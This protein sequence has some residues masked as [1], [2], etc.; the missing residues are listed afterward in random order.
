MV[1]LDRGL[2][3][4]EAS[5]R[6]GGGVRQHG[7]LLPEVP[8]AIAAVRMWERLDAELG[9]PTSY[10]QC[11][12]MYVAENDADMAKLA[13][14]RDG[15]MALGLDSEI[16]GPNALRELAPAIAGN[17]PGAKF[18]PTDGAA[19]PSTA[20]MA[21]AAAAEEAGAI[22]MPHHAVTAIGRSGNRVDH[23][24]AGDLRVEAPVVVN[25][26]GPWAPRIAEMVDV[27]LPIYPSRANMMISAPTGPIARPFVQTA[28]MDMAVCQL[29]DGSVRMGSGATP[30]DV[31]RF[32]YRKAFDQPLGDARPPPKVGLL[33]PALK[34]VPLRWRW[35]GIRECTPD[36]MPIIGPVSGVAGGPEGF[37]VSAGYSGH[38]FCLGPIAGRLAAE[39]LVEGRPSLDLSAFAYHR[40]LRPEGPLSVIKVLLEQTG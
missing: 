14:M 25:A 11:G 6:N 33:F 3:G 17:L 13:R 32:T 35:S 16:I 22:L 27:Y 20:T 1:V 12:H 31:S 5:G 2:I 4:A 28:S 26:A 21:I 29:P 18:C 38:G 37:F 8:L 7:R 24:I 36:M 15:E 23:V 19:D 40:F 30:N 34:D 10:R 9:R 39:W